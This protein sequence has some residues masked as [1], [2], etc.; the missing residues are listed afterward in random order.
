MTR[1]MTEGDKEYI[2]QNYPE[3]SYEEIA[4]AIGKTRQQVE[5][6]RLFTIKDMEIIQHRLS[7]G[8]KQSDI[9]RDYGVHQVTISNIKLGRTKAKY[10]PESQSLKY[11]IWRI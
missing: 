11:Q 2:T 1:I 6:W 5:T 10:E 9:A 7:S 8:E 4:K 3:K